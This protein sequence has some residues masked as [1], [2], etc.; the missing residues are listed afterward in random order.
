MNLHVEIMQ[1]PRQLSFTINNL[2]QIDWL[3]Q[4]LEGLVS[5]TQSKLNTH[6]LIPVI[7]VNSQIIMTFPAPSRD[8]SRFGF[9]RKNLVSPSS[10]SV[11]IVI[12]HL[13]I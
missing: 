8:F 7:H 13:Q 1:K 12:L 4:Q 10:F 9:S 2:V 6:H 3:L 11:M 5:S